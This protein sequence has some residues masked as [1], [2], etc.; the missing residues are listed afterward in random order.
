MSAEI[1][2]AHMLLQCWSHQAKRIR[3]IIITYISYHLCFKQT[4][5]DTPLQQYLQARYLQFLPRL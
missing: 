3:I 5:N 4:T 1:I 2:N